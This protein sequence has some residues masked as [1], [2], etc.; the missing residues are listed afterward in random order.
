MVWNTAPS[1]Q[2]S[3]SDPSRPGGSRDRLRQLVDLLSE[4]ECAHLLSAAQEVSDGERFWEGDSGLFYNDYV[5]LRFFRVGANAPRAPVIGHD[6]FVPMFVTKSY[7]GA[8]RR[9]L[10]RPAELTVDLGTAMR[11]RRSRRQYTKDPVDLAAL[12]AVL[13]HGCGVSATVEAYG[14]ERFPLRTFP[15]H[16]GLQS[17][18]LYVCARTVTDLQSGIYHYEPRRHELELLQR[19]DFADRLTAISF[20]EQYVGEAAAVLLVTG[21]HGRLRWKYGERAYRF[22]C[23][24]AGFLGENLYLACEGLGLGAC[25][26]SGFAQDAAEEMLD[27][28]G[29]EELAVLMLTI[30]VPAGETLAE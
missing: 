18:E 17:P 4:D 25:A 8:E 24:D 1:S 30:G 28:D 19:G 7:P 11:G 13:H 16:G 29:R 3:W 5:K 9:T 22:L 14:F 2:S 20:G 23:I 21:M 12:S 26:V 6:S 27:I 10:P 15:T